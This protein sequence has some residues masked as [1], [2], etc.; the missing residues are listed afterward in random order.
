MVSEIKAAI[1]RAEKMGLHEHN[2]I[3]ALK[4]I[5]KQYQGK[6]KLSSAQDKY[7]NSLLQ[8]FS[9]QGY[10]KYKDWKEEWLT[11]EHTRE[12]GK[13]IS[14]YYLANAGWFMAVAKTVRNC[15]K[16]SEDE[17]P[18]IPDFYQFHKMTLN[19]YAEK[20]WKSHISPL[21]WNPGELVQVRSATKVEGY[22][23]QLRQ[24]GI[25][26]RTDPCMVIEVNSQAISN[27][28]TWDEKKGGCRWVKVNPVGSIHLFDVM[29]KDLKKYR[30]PKASKK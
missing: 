15:L 13:V 3:E 11:N 24:Q 17:I 6:G 8:R 20:V 27:A 28:A 23:Y 14:D 19:P 30:R 25:N 4:S 29:E 22:T 1:V 26:L 18:I 21:R 7:L 5:L 16:Q 10:E 2:K 9:E 12:R